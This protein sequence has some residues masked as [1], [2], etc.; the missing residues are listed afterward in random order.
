MYIESVMLSNYLCQPLLL[1]LRSS[2][3]SIRVFSSEF[4]LPIR[5]PK[6][7]NFS[8]NIQ[9]I[10]Y[11]FKPE[12]WID[13]FE[14]L[15]VQG[16][17]KSLFPTPQLKSIN[18][19]VLSFPYSPTLTSTLYRSIIDLQHSVSD[20]QKV[21]QLYMCPFFCRFFSHVGYYRI[22]NRVPCAVQEVLVDYL[23]CI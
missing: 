2:P 16:T 14:L 9:W 11:S 15:E 12:G 6:Y 10:K 4:T 5:W 21:I 20:A 3:A 18:S 19:S 7:W 8:F 13:W 17:L 22:L 23:F 1:C